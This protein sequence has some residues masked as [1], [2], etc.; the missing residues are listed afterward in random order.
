MLQ[1]KVP[2]SVSDLELEDSSLNFFSKRF[3]FYALAFVAS[4]VRNEKLFA[5]KS[6]ER[7]FFSGTQQ[8]IDASA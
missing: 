4:L 7:L 3:S 1:S 8:M 2:F 6:L 5:R